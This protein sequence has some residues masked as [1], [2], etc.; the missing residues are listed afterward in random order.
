MSTIADGDDLRVVAGVDTHKDVHVAVVLDE[1]GRLGDTASLVATARGYK[2]LTGWVT[3]F[4]EV[5]A[6]G[7]EGTGSWGAGLAR[8]LR[9]R[10][11]SVIE[12]NKPNRHNRRRRG[13]TDPI[14]AEAAARAVLAGDATAIPKAGD[15]PVEALRQLRVARA[16]ALKARTAAANQFHSICDTAPEVV[17]GQPRRAPHPN[18]DD[19]RRPLPGR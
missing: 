8:H 12:V 2:N 14:D 6:I 19:R 10:G 15:G 5:L 9:A 4:G 13:K 17:R 7:V 1:V 18:Q 3:S 16:G 11:P